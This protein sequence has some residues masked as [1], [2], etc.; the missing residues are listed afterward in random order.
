MSHVSPQERQQ[1]NHKLKRMGFGGLED[2]NLFAQVGTL[3]T[4][5]ESFRGL[6][7]STKPDQRRQAYESLRSHLCFTPKPLDVYEQEAKLRAEKE[8]WDVFDPSNPHYPK[9]FTPG[10]V[11]SEEYRLDRL[12]TEAIK[13]NAHENRGGLEMVCIKCTVAELFRAP[14]HKDAE[15]QANEAGWRSDG[16]KNYCPQHV[17]TRVTMKL[18][19]SAENCLR[20]EKI[21]CWDPTDG[22]LK[23]RLSGWVIGDEAKCPRCSA[24]KLVLQ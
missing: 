7:M 21:R 15:K 1:I 14:T 23:A 4:T 9:A 18:K 24:P 13:Q 16:H 3:Y 2:R 12:A 5:H 8:Q 6:L 17:P 11:E 20:E 10:E 22:Y 19:C